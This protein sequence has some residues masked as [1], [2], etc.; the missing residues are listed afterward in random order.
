MIRLNPEQLVFVTERH[1]ATLTTLR[2]DGT[3]HVVPVAFTWDAAAGV[4]RITANRGS[5]KARNARGYPPR[6]GSP[7]AAVCQV[8]GG[9]WITLE[10]Q[11]DVSED[12]DE[13]TAAVARYA[14][15]YR[16]LRPNPERIVLRLTPDKVMSSTYMA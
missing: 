9:R 15:R 13:I 4:V 2:Q 3:P 12:P 14:K 11:I 16:E 8:D 10:G 6:E 1:L 7:R 5:V